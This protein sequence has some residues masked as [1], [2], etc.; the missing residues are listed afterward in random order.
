MHVFFTYYSLTKLNQLDLAKN[1]DRNISIGLSITLI[2][3]ALL[4]YSKLYTFAT[5]FLLAISLALLKFYF[6]VQWLER[7]FISYLVLLIPFFVVNGVLTGT[8]INEAIGS[9]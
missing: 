2:L 5:F 8:G 1:T 9:V 6:K 7:F 3:L 4:N